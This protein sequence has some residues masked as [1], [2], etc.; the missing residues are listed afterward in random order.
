MHTDGP[1]GGSRVF[2]RSAPGSHRCDASRRRSRK[3]EGANHIRLQQSLLGFYSGGA[4]SFDLEIAQ[5][6]LLHWP[7]ARPAGEVEIDHLL[8]LIDAP[9]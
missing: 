2:R 4:V 1:M 6:S 8:R 3:T 7:P 5:A 9:A